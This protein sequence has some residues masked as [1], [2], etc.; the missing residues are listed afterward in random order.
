MHIFPMKLTLSN[1]E[2]GSKFGKRFV[3]FFVGPNVSSAVGN[4]VGTL[5][6]RFVFFVGLSVGLSMSE[7]PVVVGLLVCACVGGSVTSTSMSTTILVGDPV[8]VTTGL[9]V[10][11]GLPL[12]GGLVT[13]EAVGLFVTTATG[14]FV[15]CLVGLGVLRR[16]VGDAVG[17]E[18]FVWRL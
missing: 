10:A 13:G 2:E 17:G 3:T 12:F 5:V 11:L 14:L 4:R 16:I 18:L 1:A 15:G 8:E 9:A 7:D 6:R